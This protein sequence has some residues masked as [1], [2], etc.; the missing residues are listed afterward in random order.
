MSTISD[1]QLWHVALVVAAA[2]TAVGALLAPIS[3]A[4]AVVF[5]ARTVDFKIAKLAIPLI[6]RPW[7]SASI[8]RLRSGL[9]RRLAKSI[10]QEDQSLPSTR[11]LG[12]NTNA[13]QPHAKFH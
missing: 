10:T 6:L 11:K 13:S 2:I 9:E 1:V 8:R 4:L 7:R 3:K 5:V 12:S